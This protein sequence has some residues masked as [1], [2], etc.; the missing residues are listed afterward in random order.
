MENLL[1]NNLNLLEISWISPGFWFLKTS[2]HPDEEMHQKQKDYNIAIMFVIQII[3]GIHIVYGLIFGQTR[4]VLILVSYRQKA[5]TY[6]HAYVCN[7]IAFTP[8]Y[9]IC[10]VCLFR[11]QSLTRNISAEPIISACI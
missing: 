1:E 3:V 5:V 9:P 2:S 4:Y 8:S 11:S 10:R 7:N 6:M